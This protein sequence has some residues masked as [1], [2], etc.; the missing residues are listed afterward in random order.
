MSKKHLG[1]VVVIIVLFSGA[2]TGLI[3]SIGQNAGAKDTGGTIVPGAKTSARIEELKSEIDKTAQYEFAY[4]CTQTNE[5]GQK[6]FCGKSK[7]RLE[8][9]NKE[10]EKEVRKQTIRSDSEVAIIKSKIRTFRGD[11]SLEA[12]YESNFSSPFNEKR[13]KRIES[14]R[15]QKG[16][17][18]WIDPETNSIVQFGPAGNSNISFDNSARLSKSDLKKRAEEY[19]D[20]HVA[21]FSEVKK[22]YMEEVGS[23]GL[24]NGSG[25]ENSFAFRWNAPAGNEDMAPFVQVVLSSAGEVM[26]FTDTRSLYVN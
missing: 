10:L 18:Y 15:D 16:F 12:E 3:I 8:A 22:K 21:D 13:A 20:K 26:S 6:V 1:V 25:S 23:K 7:D 19:L 24:T 4:G 5:F 14:Y 9:L 11:S 2:M 17:E